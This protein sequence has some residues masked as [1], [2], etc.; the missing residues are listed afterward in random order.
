M[1]WYILAALPPFF[2]ALI[3]FIDQFLARR[4]FPNQSFSLLS[5][6]T[7]AFG[8]LVIVL[9]IIRPSVLEIE[10]SL[11][12]SLMALGLLFYTG[13]IPYIF[14]IQQEEASNAAP[15]FETIPF[16]TAIMG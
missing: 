4:F 2:W 7:L 13:V 3:N 6:A 10:F 11:A 12:L 5:F 15:L 14:A 1:S 8:I 9:T 16:F